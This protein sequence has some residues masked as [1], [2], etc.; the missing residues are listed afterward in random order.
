MN[1]EKTG[2][3]IA[4]LRREKQFTQVQLADTIRVS[5]K[6]VSRW[7]TGRGFPDIDNLEALSECLDVSI[8]ELMLMY[9]KEASNR[10]QEIDR[11][12]YTIP[13]Q[14]PKDKHCGKI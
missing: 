8:A 5:D 7:E 1:I 12:H 4:E 9:G 10:K 11:Q 14:R 6:A 13:N 3:F 2:Q